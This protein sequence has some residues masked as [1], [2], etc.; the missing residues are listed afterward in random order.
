MKAKGTK[1]KSPVIEPEIS[2]RV[3]EQVFLPW[4]AILVI[5]HLITMYIAPAYMWG[6]H[7]YH[8]F[9]VWIGWIL[10]LASLAI[11]IPGIGESLY[12]IIEALA[13]KIKTPFDAL[14]QNKLFLVLSL[15]SLPLFWIFRTR[16]HLLGDGY[17]RI[18]DLPRGQLHLQEWL[19]GLVHLVI[20]RVM[21]NLISSWTPELT[22]ST[23]SILCGGVFVF[24]S[25]KLSSL[26]GKTGL[27]KVLIF[28]FLICLGSVQ[29]FFGYV[30]SYAIL[31]VVLLA[32][33]WLAA[34]YLKDKISIIPVLLIFVMSVG[35][36]VTSLIFAPS[37][38]YLFLKRKK[39]ETA[40][41]RKFGKTI[42]NAFVFA[43][44]IVALFLVI[45]WVL[46]V[47]IG[48][49][50]TGKG[51]FILPLSGT[52]SYRFGMFSLA[53]ISEFVNQLLL[54]SPLGISL[55]IFYL[56]F[57][58]KFNFQ[59]FR[60]G[61]ED[62]LINLLILATFFSL[63]Y[64]FVFNFTLG[65]ADW[66]LR[67]SPALFLGLL[68][69]L[70]FLRWGEGGMVRS[71]KDIG[72]TKTEKPESESATMPGLVNSNRFKVWGFIFIWFGLFHTVPWILINAHQQR[73][74]NR[75]VLI[76][77]NDPHPVDETGYNLYKISRILQ[78]A[79]Q[80]EEVEKMYQ[81]A[82]D[83]NPY[84][85]LSYFN[86]ATRYY[87]KQEFDQAV[88]VLDTLLKLDP[89]YPKANWMIGNIYMKS[90]EYG[91]ALFYLEKAL[92]FL[93]DN[94][95]FLFNLG[96]SYYYSD[97]PNAALSCGLEIVRLVPESLA[98]RHILGLAYAKL[99][100]FENAKQ[101]WEYILSVN[102][103]D[104]VAITNLIQA[105]RRLQ[106]QTP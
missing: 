35:L 68:G 101:A 71:E 74:I 15:L 80:H 92:P 31:Q 95:D 88:L 65:S 4:T 100:D 10:T 7:F 16:L 22:Y 2:G 73:S 44:L 63:I 102:P 105:Q 51:I 82:I 93:A 54:L 12:E 104:S 40:A 18:Q 48:L 62:G 30:E 91:K 56:F 39:D 24:L 13:K 28:S 26:L 43:A 94:V 84:D 29:L 21:N 42:S 97:Q 83:K 11:L 58:I 50:R 49:E 38:I 3:F 45:S 53:H 72:K 19:D 89:Q 37:F 55:I 103:N 99:G 106:K 66:D 20:Y 25:L 67:S 60:R 76:Q 70:L 87:K 77:T 41:K 47:A 75:Y 85:T 9:P 17:F 1:K 6:I 69:V 61:F 81:R 78:L 46:V 52:G 8:F 79:G 86:L 64:L 32:Y 96:A 27:G 90:K 5:S 23:I 98:A 57:K 33:V 59:G 34:L 36:H 14:S